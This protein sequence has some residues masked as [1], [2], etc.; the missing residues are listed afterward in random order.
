MSLGSDLSESLHADMTSRL[1][2]ELL[3][4]VKKFADLCA[5]S[6]VLSHRLGHAKCFAFTVTFHRRF[7]GHSEDRMGPYGQKAFGRQAYHLAHRCCQVL[8]SHGQ[9][10]P[11]RKCLPL[12]E[13]GESEREN[14]GKRL[15][16]FALHPKTCK[17]M[18]AKGRKSLTGRGGSS[19]TASTCSQ[20][21]R[22]GLP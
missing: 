16:E 11:S 9:V 22:S 13:A 5:P 10:R 8:Q 3:F 1:G 2:A 12:Q 20:I 6:H 18:R 4:I 17:K 19:R 15:S 7:W 14:H 21:Q